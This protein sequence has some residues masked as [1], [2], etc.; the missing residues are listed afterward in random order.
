VDHELDAI[1]GARTSREPQ[2]EPE[3][4]RAVAEAVRDPLHEQPPRAGTGVE[5][6]VHAAQIGA[7]HGA[8]GRVHL[9]RRRPRRAAPGHHTC[10][11]SPASASAAASWP[12]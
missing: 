3:I 6:G 12:V 9:T 11:S 4:H 8:E 2:A 7:R 5:L 1:A 10:T